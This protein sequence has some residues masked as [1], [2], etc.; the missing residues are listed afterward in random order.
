M[1]RQRNLKKQLY[2][3][4]RPTVHTNPSQKRSFWKTLFKRTNL[5]T[6]TW[7]VDGKHFEN[8]ASFWNRFRDSN[9]VVSLTEFYSTSNPQW[10]VIVVL[11]NFSGEVWTENI[12]CVFR[13]KTLFLTSSSVDWRTWE[14]HFETKPRK[15]IFDQFSN[16]WSRNSHS[17]LEQL[18]GILSIFFSHRSVILKKLGQRWQKTWYK[19]QP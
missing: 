9:H 13:V 15:P 17:Y 4:V 19:S 10:S 6:L 16:C 14:E 12:W 5:K 18:V 2:F 1:L 8:V 7:I 3:Y 11:S